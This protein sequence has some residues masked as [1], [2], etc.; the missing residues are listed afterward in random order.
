[1]CTLHAVAYFIGTTDLPD[2]EV[3]LKVLF[4]FP[5]NPCKGTVFAEYKWNAT[6]GESTKR[7]REKVSPRPLNITK[8][9]NVCDFIKKWLLI[10]IAFLSFYSVKQPY[11]FRITIN[12]IIFVMRC[13]TIERYNFAE[14]LLFVV[15]FLRFLFV[16]EWSGDGK[17]GVHK[18][19]EIFISGNRYSSPWSFSIYWRLLIGPDVVVRFLFTLLSRYLEMCFDAL[20]TFVT[21]ELHNQNSTES[22]SK[23]QYESIEKMWISELATKQPKCSHACMHACTKQLSIRVSTK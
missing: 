1:M 6:L 12:A 11:A 3:Q 4:S 21:K 7:K 10:T 13:Q 18:I 15:L 20:D 9:C 23:Q 17:F 14:A 5:N 19:K 2:T 8:E 16:L 22:I